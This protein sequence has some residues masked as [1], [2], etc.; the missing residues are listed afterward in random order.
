MATIKIDGIKYSSTSD[1]I[2]EV[3][4]SRQTLWRW[5]QVAKV[6]QGHRYRDGRILFTGDEIKAIREFANHIEP[7]DQESTNQLK[8]FDRSSA[9]R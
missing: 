6:P 9:V 7:I 5:R 4:I 3:G 8:L 2:R 1:V